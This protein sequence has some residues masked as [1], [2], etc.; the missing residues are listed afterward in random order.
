MKFITKN[1]ILTALGLLSLT[2]TV[3]AQIKVKAEFVPRKEAKEKI[4]PD[5]QNLSDVVRIKTDADG[6]A[7]VERVVFE[8]D[9]QFRFEVKKPPYQFDWDTL[10]ETDGAHTVGII[11]YNI[12]GQTGTQ[13]LKVKVENKLALGMEHWV[14]A[15]WAAFRRGDAEE[16][17]RAV[18]KAF[19][20]NTR[21]PQAARLMALYRGVQGDIGGGF[22]ML[23]DN[24]NNIP[25]DDSATLDVIA[26]LTLSRGVYAGKTEEMVT[27]LNTALA[28]MKPRAKGVVREATAAFPPNKSDTKGHIARGDMCFYGNQ[29]EDALKAYELAQTSA[30]TAALRR[31]A[32]RRIALTLISLNRMKDAG[33]MLNQLLSGNDATATDSALYGT[34]LFKDRQYQAARDTVRDAGAKRNVAGLCVAVLSDLALGA[35]ATA[36]KEA[37]DAVEIADTAETQY[38]AQAA[39]ADAG[40]HENAKKSFQAAFL[41]APFFMPTLVS[42]GYEIMAYGKEESRFLDASNI[43]DAVLRFDP[44]N[45]GALAGRSLAYTL[46]KRTAAALP[47]LKR[48]QNI[49]PL[50]PDLAILS[51]VQYEQNKET[52]KAAKDAL[53]RARKLDPVNFKDTIVPQMPEFAVRMTRLRRVV[54]MSP[55]LLDIADNPPP[56]EPAVTTAS[57]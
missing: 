28:I 55:R 41:R 47:L 9:D 11:A 57:K 37:R 40:D 42:R 36:Y 4:A 1:M 29:F 54:P 6:S 16:M 38:I 52:F 23:N 48:L 25:K 46:Q 51:A 10:A 33:K 20:I 31:T 22:G 32:N 14:G 53:E 17:A 12:N 50:A 24:Q 43:F 15:G 27:A 2:L 5:P 3:E 49:D 39:L 56:V 19:K 35:R 21:D 18:R 45:A 34:Y 8:V 7:G 44:D 30:D 26:Y 13:R